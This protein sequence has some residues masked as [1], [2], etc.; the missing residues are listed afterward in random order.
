MD[1]SWISAALRSSD[2]FT[3][4]HLPWSHLRH[5]DRR[6]RQLAMEGAAAAALTRSAVI[7]KKALRRTVAERQERRCGDGAIILD[8]SRHVAPAGDEIVSDRLVSHAKARC[9]S[10]QRLALRPQFHHASAPTVLPS[11]QSLSRVAHEPFIKVFG[12]GRMANV[13]NFGDVTLRFAVGP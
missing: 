1:R 13:K 7:G 5:D 6:V 12:H 9:D 4:P 11:R 10:S 8:G 2:S 3:I